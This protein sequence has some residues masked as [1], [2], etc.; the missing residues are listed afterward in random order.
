MYVSPVLHHGRRRSRLAGTVG[1]IWL[2]LVL[3]GGVLGLV[4]PASAIAATITR[5]GTFASTGLI[6]VTGQ[7]RPASAGYR[8][9]L[10]ERVGSSWV[11]RSAASV[12]R[13]G[14]YAVRWRIKGARRTTVSVRVVVLRKNGRTFTRTR[15]LQL[16]RRKTRSLPTPAP[17]GPASPAPG[18][19]PGA[20]APPS[21][22][23]PLPGGGSAPTPGPVP[24][25]PAAP[26]S[27]LAAGESLRTGDRLVSPNGH[28]QLRMQPDGNLGVFRGDTAL[29]WS[30][31]GQPGGSATMQ[32]DGNLVVRTA[33]AA[34]W[35]TG[36]EGHH[37]A[38]LSLHDDGSLMV[39]AGG[40]PVWSRADGYLG[41]QLAP[42]WVLRPGQR[43]LSPNRRYELRMQTDG[44][45][46]LFE[47]STARWYS[48]NGTPGAH[49]ELQQNNG[50]FAV[51]NG[52]DRR[53]SAETWSLGAERVVLQDD[54]NL[55]VWA[56]GR[57][58][59]T[60][61]DGYSGDL[62]LRGWELRSG[63]Q[64]RS[65]DGRWT[66]WMQPDG[67]LGVW[68]GETARW[69]S[70]NGTGGAH[71]V[72]HPANGNFAVWNGTDMRWSAGTADRDA[73]RV[74]LEGDGNLV[75]YAG[76]TMLWSRIGGLVDP[77]GPNGPLGI[78]GNTIASRAEARANG[79]HEG[80]CLVF[81]SNMIGEAGGPR[82]QFG[83]D[84]FVYQQKWRDF[85]AV[86][87]PSIAQ[88]RRGDIVQWGG[89]AGDGNVH[90]AIVTSAGPDPQLIDSNF[91]SA[92]RVGRGSFS[93]RNGSFSRYRIWRVG[94]P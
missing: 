74:K 72:L 49:A 56:A 78:S 2:T 55:V 69:W 82:W 89:E 48:G 58:V 59:W 80:Q 84:E 68:E 34:R 92:E 30:G 11:A 50:N 62:L 8:A 17:P 24:V 38:E 35:A 43:L 26:R 46:G 85:G 28:Y 63:S 87:I 36:T 45:L 23:V 40:R 67:N 25:V 15:P 91:G 3:C 60:S 18:P 64:L 81:A 65:T 44:N 57:P 77:A 75:V 79:T 73:S 6:E 32:G 86:E 42:G 51:W 61:R 12:L 9:R 31:N 10:E 19:G 83:F 37:G 20:P 14:R 27:V 33:G 94:Q 71:A 76:T 90:T 13:N 21:G 1:S 70:G 41:G 4:A 7:V 5:S 29:W 54:G 52:S 47:G 39:W 66:A 93:S 88:A 53:W 16:M 22:A